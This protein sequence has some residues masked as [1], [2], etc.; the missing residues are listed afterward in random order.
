MATMSPASAP[1][2]TGWRFRPR[3]ASTL[4]MRPRSIS[5]PSRS[6]AWI[7]R[8]GVALPASTRPVSRRPR[9]GSLSI[10]T[11]SIWKGSAPRAAALG[12]GTWRTIRS[13]SG[14]RVSLGRLMSSVAQPFLPEA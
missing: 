9:K 11:P 14:A 10:S 7:G 4:V 13:N 8:P 12:S 3:K 6:R 1:S 5:R 2:S